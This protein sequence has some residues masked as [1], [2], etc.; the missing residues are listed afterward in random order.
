MG[1]ISINV[2]RM[3]LVSRIFRI[4]FT[5]KQDKILF[6]N[7]FQAFFQEIGHP[8]LGIFEEFDDNLIS[9]S[10]FKLLNIDATPSVPKAI[11]KCSF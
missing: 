8:V 9:P 11:A 7:Y 1:A 4:S 3:Y 6:T 5:G 2:R 10:L